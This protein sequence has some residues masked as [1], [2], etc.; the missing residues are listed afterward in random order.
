[1]LTTVFFDAAGT[2]I[3]LPRPVGE[4]YAEVARRCGGWDASAE[5]MNG[6][7]RRAWKAMPARLPTPDAGPRPGDDRPWWRELVGRVLAEVPPPRGFDA[8]AYFAAVYARFAEPGVWALFPDV[9]ETLGFLRDRGLRLAVVSNFDRRLRV[10]LGHL[11][12]TGHFERVIL[13]SEEGADKPDPRIFQRALGQMG[14]RAAETLHVGDEPAKDGGA[15]AAGV[16][17]FH[18]DRPAR[19]L[20]ALREAMCRDD[21]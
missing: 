21:Y 13:S 4:H 11:G 6:A 16:R 19:G 17:V 3:H 5:A 15:E 7:F 1:M 18:L 9:V 14:A 20:A 2:L 10:V 8:E 12:L